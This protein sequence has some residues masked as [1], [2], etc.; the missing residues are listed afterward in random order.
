MPIANLYTTWCKAPGPRR[1]PLCQVAYKNGAHINTTL[2]LGTKGLLYQLLGFWQWRML[3]SIPSST[4]TLCAFIC[5][6]FYICSFAL[7]E[8]LLQCYRWV[9]W[10]QAA[11]HAACRTAS[12]YTSKLTAIPSQGVHNAWWFSAKS[13]KAKYQI[14]SNNGLVNFPALRSGCSGLMPDLKLLI[15]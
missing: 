5:F 14:I 10:L 7:G 11:F 1:L 2:R 13:N 4:F 3:Y 6:L 12:H 8:G 15:L 9:C